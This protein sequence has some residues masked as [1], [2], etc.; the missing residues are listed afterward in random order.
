MILTSKQINIEQTQQWFD[1]CN[2][3][4]NPVHNKIDFFD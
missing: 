1:R 3:Y 4:R 2:V